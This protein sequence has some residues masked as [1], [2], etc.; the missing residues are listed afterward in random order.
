M[1]GEQS[2]Q[3]EEADDVAAS[4]NHTEHER[5][6]PQPG[7]TLNRPWRNSGGEA[8]SVHPVVVA[9]CEALADPR[10]ERVA[11]ELFNGS[12][13]AHRGRL[14]AARLTRGHVWPDHFRRIDNAVELRL[15]HE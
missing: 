6:E 2:P 14:A 15:G 8:F 7:R 1:G 11:V 12:V 3:A 4:G 9:G 5:E 10:G 13:I